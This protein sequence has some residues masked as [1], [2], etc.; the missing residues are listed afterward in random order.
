VAVV[1]LDAEATLARTL[2]SILA[3]D[4]PDLEVIVRDGASRDGTLAIIRAYQDHLDRWRSEPD[5]GPYEAMNAAA[6]EA[7]GRYVL[8]MNAGDHFH[9]TDAITQA[10]AGAPADATVVFGHH[11]YRDVHGIEEIHASASFDETWALL[12]SGHIGWR[13][14]SRVPG[15]QATFTATEF[16]RANPYRSDLRIAAD[17]ELLYRAARQGARFHHCGTLVAT[18][19]AGGFSWRNRTRCFEEWRRIALEYSEHPARVEAAFAEMRQDMQREELPHLTGPRL[20]A[21]IGRTPGATREL[22]R[23][24]R[25]RLGR[26]NRLWG[27][28]RRARSLTI[29]FTDPSPQGL[30]GTK[31]LST[32]ERFGR[33]TEGKRALIL[34][35]PGLGTARALSLEIHDVF[36]PNVGKSLRIHVGGRDYSRK[37][38]RGKQRVRVKL[39]GA[40]ATQPDRIEVEIPEPASPKELG[41]NDDRRLLGV[42]LTALQ[43]RLARGSR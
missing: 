1:T 26:L 14:L 27:R 3:Q 41:Y 31:G 28:A 10:M 18:Y 11:V 6:R 29:P 21:R 16:L 12:R 4:W 19:L 2:D 24:V 30:L 32:P 36:G 37:L 8:F 34:L 43:I 9:S 15:H 38:R 40:D 13:W 25:R 5:G 33:W 39:V 22:K 20:L 42:A 23:R 17:H 7:T 35:E